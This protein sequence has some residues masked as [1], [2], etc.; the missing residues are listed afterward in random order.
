MT[1]RSHEQIDPLLEEYQQ[2]RTE[3]MERVGA[4]ETTDDVVAV[5]DPQTLIGGIAS[6]QA[7]IGDGAPSA[8]VLAEALGF[9]HG[10]NPMPRELE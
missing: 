10:A 5:Q 2:G 9:V 1:E 7:F 3:G 6:M 8:A 4:D